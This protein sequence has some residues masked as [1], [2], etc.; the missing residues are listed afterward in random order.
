MFALRLAVVSP[1]PLDSHSEDI[2]LHIN[3]SSNT[4]VLSASK[5][6]LFLSTWK[7]TL[8]FTQDKNLLGATSLVAHEHFVKQENCRS[9]KSFIQT[10]FST[11]RNAK[12]TN[13]RTQCNLLAPWKLPAVHLTALKMKKKVKSR[14]LINLFLKS[15]LPQTILT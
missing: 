13:N 15:L 2:W 3:Q 4:S 8:T 10:L 12:G 14:K 5:A 6:L 9:T 7:N 1:I 11:F